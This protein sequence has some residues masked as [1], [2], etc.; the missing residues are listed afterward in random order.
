MSIHDN[1]AGTAPSFNGEVESDTDESE[2]ESTCETDGQSEED[3]DDNDWS[4]QNGNIE[5]LV[6]SAVGSDYSLAA[7]LIPLL[8]RDFN[9]A[10]KSK[11]ENWRCT[12]TARGGSGGSS[13]AKQPPTESSPD[14]GAGSSRKRRRTNSDGGSHEE[15]DGWD[16]GED[17]DRDDD[18]RGEV[19]ARGG[20][21]GDP[22]LMLA[23]PFHKLDPIKYG[24]H[25]SSGP[26]KRSKYAYR[27][28]A[29][30]GFRSI[31]RLK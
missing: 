15:K 13:E 22:N 8:H 14:Q 23:C 9:L 11:V 16:E 21:T 26:V 12:T 31:Q 5:S 2:C 6:I 30:P 19:G 1:E 27:A 10:L 18:D 24:V 3:D 17:E 29:G 25:G 20:L 7:F 4:G 28:C